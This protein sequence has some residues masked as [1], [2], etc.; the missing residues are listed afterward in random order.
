MAR[1]PIA[2]SV[3]LHP[4]I[5]KAEAEARAAAAAAEEKEEELLVDDIADEPLLLDA[6]APE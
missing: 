1:P 3:H 5:A 2:A 6:A 4:E